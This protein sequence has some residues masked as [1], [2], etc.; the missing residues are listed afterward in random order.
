MQ[1]THQVAQSV[2]SDA[3]V[4]YVDN[5]PLVL[6]Q[7]RVLLGSS[8]AEGRT[9]YVDADYREPAEI[10]AGARAVLDFDQPV[11]VLFMGVFGYVVDAEEV[12]SIIARIVDAVPSGSYL[13]LWDGTSTSAEAIAGAKAQ[14]DL[15][16]PYHLRTVAEIESWFG[17][18]EL[19]EP[20]VVPVPRWRPDPGAADG[21]EPMDGYGGV[22]RK[23]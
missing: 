15:G 14:A 11:G 13:A 3:A 18:W 7:A 22:A 17:G 10:I 2:R 9:G 19:V 1:N 8:S 23:P 12:R 5:D 6:A 20:G 4:V 16:S 21:A